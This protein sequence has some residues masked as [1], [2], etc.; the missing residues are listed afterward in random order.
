VSRAGCGGTSVG[1]YRRGRRRPVLG[2]G[3]VQLPRGPSPARV[4]AG[5]TPTTSSCSVCRPTTAC[6]ASRPIVKRVRRSS[7]GSR[8][9]MSGILSLEATAATD[10]A[11]ASALFRCGQGRG[12]RTTRRRGYGSG[13]GCAKMTGGRLFRT[14]IIRCRP[15]AS[16]RPVPS[17]WRPYRQPAAPDLPPDHCLGEPGEVTNRGHNGD[18][19]DGVH[20]GTF[21]ADSTNRR[22]PARSLH[23]VLPMSSLACS[24]ESAVGH[25]AE[26][27]HAPDRP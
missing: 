13:S 14:S 8:G 17:A 15:A 7:S 18:C 1:G 5:A 25:G 22:Q 20:L 24:R 10:A 19:C 4:G 9:A 16:G 26:G 3:L 6:A 12:F 11:F 2:H 27:H 21:F 23:A